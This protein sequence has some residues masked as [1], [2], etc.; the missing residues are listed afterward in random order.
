MGEKWEILSR[1]KDYEVVVAGDFALPDPQKEASVNEEWNRA[2]RKNS[3]LTNGVILA[4][5]SIEKGPDRTKINCLKAEYKYYYVGM[6]SINIG[7]ALAPLAVSGVVRIQDGEGCSYVMARRSKK[8]GFYKNCLEFFPSTGIDCGSAGEDRNVDFTQ[9]I[10]RGF[11]DESGISAA[12]IKDIE[13][14]ALVHDTGGGVYDICAAIDIDWSERFSSSFIEASSDGYSEVVTV[15]E[16]EL[17][18]II[19]RKSYEIAPT[20]LAIARILASAQ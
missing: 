19:K 18:N 16:S 9:Q 13:P 17:K 5:K 1:H 10:S 3:S 14:F 15:R 2:V 4:V 8:V 11:E 7:A 6:S 20:S 12:E